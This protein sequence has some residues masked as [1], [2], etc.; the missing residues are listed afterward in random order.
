MEGLALLC[1]GL[2]TAPWG[3]PGAVPGAGV[4]PRR[5]EAGSLA[6]LF[7][8]CPGQQLPGVALEPRSSC[9]NPTLPLGSTRLEVCGTEAPNGQGADLQA[10][11]VPPRSLRAHRVP[12]A[13][14][15]QAVAVLTAAPV[16]ALPPR[17][18]HS[19]P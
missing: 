12:A 3:A 10:G 7:Q 15:G 16:P 8:C 19:L 6:G 11:R 2:R 17:P 13:S 1:P 18:R 5:A 4:A 9:P 14:R